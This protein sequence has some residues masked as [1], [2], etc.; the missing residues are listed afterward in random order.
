MSDMIERVA[1]RLEPLAWAALGA[2]DTLD[3]RNRRETSL[4]KARD[5]MEAMMEP[6]HAMEDA[7]WH[8]MF[9]NASPRAVMQAMITAAL[10]PKE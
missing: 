4:H 6:T 10:N 7:A 5:A 9:A 3:Y 2:G 8:L 1:R